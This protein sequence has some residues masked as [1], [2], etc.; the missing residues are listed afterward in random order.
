MSKFEVLYQEV[1]REKIY[2]IEKSDEEYM[3]PC[4]Y[5]IPMK[6]E[7]PILEAEIA[8]SESKTVKKKPSRVSTKRNKTTVA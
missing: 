6:L 5:L 7:I 8:K 3:V 4:P 2:R 1:P